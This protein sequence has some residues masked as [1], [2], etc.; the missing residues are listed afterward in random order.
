[1]HCP[2]PSGWPSHCGC[3]NSPM[4][5]RRLLQVP[6]GTLKSQVACAKS[7]CARPLSAWQPERSNHDPPPITT[8]WIP[9]ERGDKRCAARNL[10]AGDV[11]RW[12]LL[13]QALRDLAG[14]H[15]LTQGFTASG[16]GP[17]RR[18]GV[19]VGCA[20]PA[21]GRRAQERTQSRFGWGGAA[22]GLGCRWP[23][24]CRAW[25]VVVAG[26]TATGPDRGAGVVRRRH[27]LTV[28]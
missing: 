16:D 20:G 4:K 5:R 11:A 6:L 21:C 3:L 7:A 22:M 23:G 1:M 28:R 14:A 19:A 24:C 25:P 2:R 12:R 26:A 17:P 27:G 13:D 15:W 8:P 10:A 18:A 9:G